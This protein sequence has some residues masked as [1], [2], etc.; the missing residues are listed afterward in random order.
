MI[1][2]FYGNDRAKIAQEVKKVL[3][4]DYEVF[5]G[6]EGLQIAD[7]VN[8]FQG[9]S[10]FASKRKIL[11]KDI[12]EL[13]LYEE[14][15]TY[16]STL[17]DILIWETTIS[18]KKAYKDFIKLPGVSVQ[19]FDAAPKI[20]IRQVFEIFDTAMTDGE[21]A[22]EMLEKVQGEEDPY[23]FFGLLASQAIRK[24]EWRQGVEQRRALQMLSELDMQMK[25]TAVEPWS[26]IKSCLLR[27][28]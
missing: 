21:R 6:A 26:L 24:F 1:K 28:S 16:V 23:M 8:I 3:G 15:A 12:A 25:T 18:Q 22:V 10:L 11:I 13:D 27:L 7:I 2:V 19:K 4:E 20:D 17:L 14:I 9:N 5:D